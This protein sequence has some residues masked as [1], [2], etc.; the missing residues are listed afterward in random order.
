MV[1]GTKARSWDAAPAKDQCSQ[2]PGFQHHSTAESATPS[3]ACPNQHP[4]N[5]RSPAAPLLAQAAS[6]G[7]NLCSAA[8]SCPLLLRH[9]LHTCQV[10]GKARLSTWMKDK[11]AVVLCLL[12]LGESGV[13]HNFIS[14]QG[15]EPIIW[16]LYAVHFSERLIT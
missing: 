1:Q 10:E 11:Q 9:P 7:L 3:P 4:T 14:L 13:N 2:Q 5:L 16:Q 6:P 15:K 8:A 12:L